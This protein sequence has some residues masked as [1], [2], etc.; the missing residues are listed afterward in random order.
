MSEKGCCK[1]D[2][3][4]SVEQQFFVLYMHRNPRRKEH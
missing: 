1:M 4:A 3:E 2:V